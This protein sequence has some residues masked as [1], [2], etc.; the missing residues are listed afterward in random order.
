MKNPYQRCLLC[1]RSC[2]INRLAGERG[3]C[4]ETAALRVAAAVLHCGE[5]PPLTG[6]G[7]SGTIFI[8]GCNL[9]C[10]FCQNYQISQGTGK[11]YRDSVIGKE[12]S[13]DGFARICLS[14]QEK[15]AEN[16]NIV[17]GSHAIPAII[18]GLLTAKKSGLTI[19][20]L[21]N[22]SAYE[23]TD[24]LEMLREIV[25]IYLP[26]LKTLG[27]G[28]AR[29]FFNAEDYPVTAKAAILKMIE[30][31]SG[32]GNNALRDRVIIRHLILPGLLESTRDVLRWFA[33]NAQNRAML[34]LM[35]QYTPVPNRNKNA[36]RRFLSEE[37][38]DTVMIWLEEFGI[39]EGFCQELVTS[40]DWL[41]DFRK[42]NPFPSELSVTVW[43]DH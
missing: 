29:R 19:P 42:K 8:S 37:E 20:V 34:S 30:M 12:V 17:T 32:T 27:S 23:T 43:S 7:G 9:G 18:G 5:E 26:D 31:A 11:K 14:V 35:T 39:E 28:I 38:Y 6:T 10:I 3:Y 15:G 22:S 24:T 4:G 21:W 2:G 33:E 25:D 40:S 41:P 1:P 16:I 13:I 36:P